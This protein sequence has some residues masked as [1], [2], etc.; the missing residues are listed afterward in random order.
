[1]ISFD[2]ITGLSGGS[3]NLAPIYSSLSYLLNCCS[4][5]Q[6][7]LTNIT[8]NTSYFNNLLYEAT[9][10]INSIMSDTSSIWNYVSTLSG[11]GGGGDIFKTLDSNYNQNEPQWFVRAVNSDAPFPTTTLTINIA[12]ISDAFNSKDF[13]NQKIVRLTND[14]LISNAFNDNTY[15]N[16]LYTK[17]LKIVSA[18]DNN[19]SVD[20]KNNYISINSGCFRD[21]LSVSVNLNSIYIGTP[22]WSSINDLRSDINIR[23]LNLRNNT[24]NVPDSTFN[25]FISIRDDIVSFK[26]LPMYLKS[27]LSMYI[28]NG[29]RTFSSGLSYNT[30]MRFSCSV[31]KIQYSYVFNNNSI[32]TYYCQNYYNENFNVFASNTS[33]QLTKYNF[34]H[35][36]KNF[37]YQNSSVSQIYDAVFYNQ[38]S[39]DYYL[40]EALTDIQL[41]QGGINS[42]EEFMKYNDMK[43]LNLIMPHVATIH[44][45]FDD[46]T[47]DYARINLPNKMKAITRKYNE[48]AM[49]YNTDL[50]YNIQANEEV[51]GLPTLLNDYKIIQSKTVFEE[52][53]P[54]LEL[55]KYQKLQD[56]YHN[57]NE[58]NNATISL[59]SMNKQEMGKQINNYFQIPINHHNAYYINSLKPIMNDATFCYFRQHGLFNY[60]SEM[61]RLSW[62]CLSN[63]GGE[64]DNGTNWLM[65]CMGLNWSA[66]IPN[67]KELKRLD[68]Y[69]NPQTYNDNIQIKGFKSCQ[70]EKINFNISVVN[71]FDKHV[72]IGPNGFVGCKVRDF[73]INLMGNGDLVNYTY[74]Q[75]AFSDCKQLR[76]INLNAVFSA[77]AFVNC[78]VDNFYINYGNIDALT[79]PQQWD[80]PTRSH[81]H[82]NLYVI[83]MNSTQTITNSDLTKFATFFGSVYTRLKIHNIYEQGF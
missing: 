81:N 67:M 46:N 24:S 54:D 69:Y 43:T 18:F 72:R 80:Y 8:N 27:S 77:N 65:N 53:T 19:S 57:L 36:A 17:M 39:F 5:V 9:T 32:F 60:A 45:C 11:G 51:F 74:D 40:N 1:M 30:G 16:I 64:I 34:A 83:G 37:G 4:S 14:T 52:I 6:N 29:L 76:D 68:I 26:S 33:G 79:N 56:C 75:C 38:H 35:C 13:T 70:A 42:I 73:N 66:V 61:P 50:E 2:D 15:N 12:T 41:I 71:G 23:E 62:A 48:Y 58:L 25:K 10:S 63:S 59:L 31:D 20:F 21:N 55:L 78:C 3:V 49:I 82:I 28:Y 7:S 44:Q 22:N 47:F